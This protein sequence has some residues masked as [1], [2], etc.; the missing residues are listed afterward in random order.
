MKQTMVLLQKQL[1]DSL[2]KDDWE[3]IEQN[4]NPSH[5]WSDEEWQIKS[6][7]S[8]NDLKLHINF[9]VDPLWD[10]NREKGEGVLAVGA[11]LKEPTT[12]QEAQAKPIIPISSKW[13]ERLPSFIEEL[14]HLRDN[15]G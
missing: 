15:D 8:S 6:L 3:I 14:S 1:K 10:V 7:R 13:E 5:W 4:K 12:Q 11:S 9:L 2:L